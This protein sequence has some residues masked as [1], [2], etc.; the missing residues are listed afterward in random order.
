MNLDGE[1][2]RVASAV[3]E[4][5][6][7]EQEGR[8]RGLILVLLIPLLLGAICAWSFFANVTLS[9]AESFIPAGLH[10]AGLA[11]YSPDK[12]QSPIRGLQIRIIEG[13]IRDRD[14]EAADVEQRATD[15][16]KALETPIPTVTPQPGDPTHTPPPTAT[17]TLP[18][19]PMTSVPTSAVTSAPSAT[20]DGSPTPTPTGTPSRTPT[21]SRTPTNP[22]PAPTATKT[23]T[24]TPGPCKVPPVLEINEPLDGSSFS[25]MDD[26][27]GQARAYDPDNVDP[28]DCLPIGDFEDDNGVGIASATPS[29]PGVEFK[30]E[31]FNGVSWITVHE[32]DQFAVRY[33]T[34]TGTGTCQTHDLGTLFWPDPD[35]GG[36][37]TPEPISSGLHKLYARAW[38]DEG[39]HSEWKYVK[40]T[41]DVDP[42]PTLT[43]SITPTPSYT[44][45]PDVCS[46]VT[47]ENFSG[48]GNNDLSW[49]I[50]N[51][52]GTVQ[53]TRIRLTWPNSNG[54]LTE[55]D[56]QGTYNWSS[57]A[58]PPSID[59][60]GLSAT[61]PGSSTKQIRFT[62]ESSTVSETHTLI[63]TF[64]GTCDKTV[65]EP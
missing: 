37:L 33:C 35:G 46:Q 20:P 6:E 30:I 53:I 34:F 52:G 55:I 16:V 42:T 19:P 27:T 60:T 9:S 59:Q 26:L 48:F 3:P 10:S 23:K 54:D 32:Q 63:L 4:P 8:R 25:W 22:P 28:D 21:A 62:F 15:V 44:P 24:A 18:P 51:N 38:D 7:Q 31:W 61:I 17:R 36:P 47:I 45:M 65:I 2:T 12:M 50:D 49:N 40:F 5:E 11:N 13:V 29:P 64:N 57:V 39:D 1:L 14:P 58:P 56:V 41:L 43:P